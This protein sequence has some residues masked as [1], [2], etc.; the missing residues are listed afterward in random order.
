M[1]YITAYIFLAWNML[2]IG[3]VASGK[4]CMRVNNRLSQYEIVENSLYLKLELMSSIFMNRLQW[5]SQ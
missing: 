1:T 4:C 5:L 3:A 2:G